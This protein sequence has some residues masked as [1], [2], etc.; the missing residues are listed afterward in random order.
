MRGKALTPQPPREKTALTPQPPLP[1]AGEGESERI[2]SDPRPLAGEG[3]PRS[4]RV[5]AV[6]ASAGR[7]K[8]AGHDSL[9]EAA[10][11]RGLPV[12]DMTL[13]AQALTHKSLVPHAPL[14]SNERLEFLGDSVLGL[15]VNE[16]LCAAFPRHSEGDLARAKSLVVC[17]SALA[18][19]ATRLDLTPLMRLGPAEEEMGGRS[20]ASII[21]DAY[22]ALVAVI[23]GE[24]GYE[25]AREFIL[26]TLAPEIAR[27]GTGGDWR[28]PK[29]VLQEQRQA[30]HLPPPVYQVAEEH[31]LPH[32]RV[33]TVEVLLDGVVVGGGVGKTKKDAERAA[34]SDALEKNP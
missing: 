29:S 3:Q 34:A 5:R 31:G 32:D 4:S 15:V 13:L 30:A 26:S 7:A 19:A 12:T 25:T 2:N 18:D 6:S 23:Y 16:Y 10:Q 20:R 17:K 14:Q 8:A 9:R 1:Q 28:D 24:R 21:A 27:L 33:Y 22:E 11:A